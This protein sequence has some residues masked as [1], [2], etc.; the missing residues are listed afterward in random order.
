[1]TLAELLA[2]IQAGQAA[3]FGCYWS[4]VIYYSGR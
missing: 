3:G 2:G 4:S 1:M